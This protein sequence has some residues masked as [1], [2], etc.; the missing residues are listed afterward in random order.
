MIIF[1]CC[2]LRDRGR[3]AQYAEKP[4][5]N[6]NR[7]RRD[8]VDIVHPHVYP[9]DQRVEHNVTVRQRT[10]PPY[11]HPQSQQQQQ[12]SN[13][14]PIDASSNIVFPRTQHSQQ[15]SRPFQYPSDDDD[16]SIPPNEHVV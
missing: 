10:L 7:G 4:S 12:R 8:R 16:W 11:R 5:N 2:W 6:P 3:V 13:Q 14:G 15:P 9:E 1:C